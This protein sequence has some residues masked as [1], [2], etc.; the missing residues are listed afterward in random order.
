MDIQTI[1]SIIGL[2]GIGGVI[3]S[4]IQ[5]VLNQKGDITK[6]VLYFSQYYWD[7]LL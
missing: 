5:Y 7:K 3:G 6:E 2:L 1:L 4:Y